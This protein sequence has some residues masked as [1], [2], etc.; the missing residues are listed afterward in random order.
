[1][2]HAKAA[3]VQIVVAI[4]KM[5]APGANI[6]RVKGQLQEKGLAPEDW[7]GDT[8]CV[9]VAALKGEGVQELLETIMLVSEVSELKATA[10]GIARASVIEAQIEQGRGPTATVIVKTG[11]LKVGDPFICGKYDGKVK[12]FIDDFGKPIKAAGPSHALQ[13]PG[14]RGTAA[15]RR[16]TRGH[17]ERASRQ[18]VS[19]ASA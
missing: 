16:R 18:T 17:G 3:K 4:T 5:D 6:D 11:T 8:I 10:G 1:M 15:C 13:G 12:S 19:A 2:N 14:L 7:G 9:P